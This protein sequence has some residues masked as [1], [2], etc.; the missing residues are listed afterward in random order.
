MKSVKNTIL[1]VVVLCGSAYG[2]NTVLIESRSVPAGASAVSIGVYV[3]NDAEL[4]AAVVPLVIRSVTPGAF[5]ADTLNLRPANRFASHL[6][7]FMITRYFPAENNVRRWE[8]GGGGYLFDGSPD[9]VSPD[10][11]F[12]VGQIYTEESTLDP[13]SDGTP[14][15]G[16]PSL[17]V[18]FG[19]SRVSGSFE[20]DTT[21]VCP[22]NH[23]L[24]VE[25]GSPPAAIVP[26]F[27]KGI[28]TIGCEC[29]CHTDP[30][31]DGIHN[32]V[33]WI[34]IRDVAR[35]AIPPIADPNPMCP[36]QTTDVNCDGVTNIVDQNLMFGVVFQGLNPDSVFCHPCP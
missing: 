12:Y 3:E 30:V 26:S 24:L 5:I 21:C 28:I 23:L 8:C 14:P 35:G 11:M 17:I 36:V 20:I 1:I 13:G 32:I 16:T 6:L 18:T 34:K 25:D 19:V 31:C 7:G 29:D 15:G 10:A 27:T 2:A 9:F 22:A 4:A 33:D